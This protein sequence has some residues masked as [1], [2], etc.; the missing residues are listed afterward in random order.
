MLSLVNEIL[1]NAASLDPEKIAI[2][3]AG[4][5]PEKYTYQQ[6]L[7]KAADVKT[8]LKNR[9]L[10]K[11]SR[12]GLL[13][14]PSHEYVAWIFGICWAG[15][16]AVPFDHN[17]TDN[18]I[19]E[20]AEIAGISAL[21]FASDLEDKAKKILG[22]LPLKTISL[23]GLPEQDP[24]IKAK[25]QERARILPDDPAMII[26]TSG[27][28][29]D[30]LGVTL[31]HRNIVS[32]NSSIAAYTHLTKASSI[33]SVLNFHHI[34]G[35]SLVF[36]HFIAAA[37][38]VIDNRFLYPNLV[39][40]TIEDFQVSSFAGVSSHYAILFN[41]SD[42]R[43]R[44]LPNLQSFLQAG[45]SMP[46]CLTRELLKIFPDKKLYLMYGQTEASPRL[47]YLDPELAAVKPG[48]VGKAIPG[49]EI[50][51]LDQKGNECP[52]EQEG[53]VVARGANITN[54]YWNNP[55]ETNKILKGGW[56]Y[57]RDIGKKDKDGDLYILGR[58]K[59][60]IKSGGKLIS[61]TEIEHIALEFPGIS[62]SA[63]IGVEDN[64]L[65]RK[66]LLFIVPSLGTKDFSSDNLIKFL[67]E[68]LPAY[69]IPAE[70]VLTATL[71]KTT[72]AKIDRKKL[73]TLGGQA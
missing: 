22:N 2:V 15:A 12:I 62:E 27:S 68:R 45:D 37:T 41:I 44:Q 16:I 36:S 13:S 14:R 56:L 48:S 1:Q 59:N 25:E 50:S 35:L 30:P 3:L 20:L 42:I 5:C 43:S 10:P 58:E 8:F 26:F 55:T 38:V 60:L 54:G 23:K 66:I 46:P 73:S 24:T 11:N 7:D 70:I 71:P 40:D 49:V 34:F 33:C 52:P 39:L 19:K 29:G 67:R 21:F 17:A 9:E 69:K 72:S 53:I 4:S 47:S 64:I 65:G 32:N 18:K 63:A 28:T 31:S 61:P 51:I 6:M 57:T